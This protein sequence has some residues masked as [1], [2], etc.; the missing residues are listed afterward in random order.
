M[1]RNEKYDLKTVA[2]IVDS[3]GLGYA[4]TSYMSESRIADKKLAKLWKQARVVLQK[5]EDML[6][7]P[8][9]DGDSD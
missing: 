2:Q 6:P 4:I 9:E 5:I 1:P 8:H 3:E 7:D